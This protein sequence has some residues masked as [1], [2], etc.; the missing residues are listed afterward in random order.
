MSVLKDVNDPTYAGLKEPA[1]FKAS[2]GDRGALTAPEDPAD[3]LMR[4]LGDSSDAASTQFLQVYL[5]FSFALSG[6]RH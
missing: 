3:R 6:I 5:K 4:L 2:R 1:R